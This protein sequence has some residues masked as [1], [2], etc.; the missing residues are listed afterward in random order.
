M[1]SYHFM[2]HPLCTMFSYV[3]QL[4]LKN[5]MMTLMSSRWR[6][7]AVLY[8]QGSAL[9]FS[10]LTLLVGR[11][12]EQPVCKNWLMRCWCGYLSGARCR[13][14]AYGPADATAS[15]NPIISCIIYVQT[16]FYLS[17]T[18]LP[19][20]SWKRGHWA[21]VVVIVIVV[22]VVVTCK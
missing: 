11:Q 4:L 10:T 9:A 17:G 14:F 1:T 2:F 18:S 5:F 19:R 15:Q 22:I 13:L 12:E 7:I 3:W 16:G 21:N 8:L 20:L 6:D